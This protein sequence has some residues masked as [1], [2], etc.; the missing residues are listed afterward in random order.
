MSLRRCLVLMTFLVLSLWGAGTTKA[1]TWYVRADGG[2]RAQCDGKG[3]AAYPGHG[4]NRHCALNDMRALWDAHEY[5][6]LHWVIA[7]GDTVILDNTKQ[8]RIGWDTDGTHRDTEQWCWGWDQAP[9]GC[10]NPVIPAGTAQKHTRILGRNYEH[11]NVGNQPDKSKMTQVFGGHGVWTTMFLGSA[12]YVDVQCLEVTRHSQCVRHGEPRLPKN[13][14]SDYPLDDYDGDGMFTDASTHDLLLQD[15]WI[16][17]H[18]DRGINGAIGGVV[19]ANRVIISTNGMA[20]WD[21]DDGHQTQSVN[22]VWNFLNS[23]IE[24]SGCNQEYPAVHP[25][26]VVACY[27]QSNGGYGDS[28]GTPDTGFDVNI[29]H[30]VFRYNVQDGPDFLHI[31]KGTHKL[32]I[33]N[34]RSY[35]NNGDQF[36][37]GDGFHS[38]LFVNNLVVANCMRLSQTMPGTP[39]GFNAH[40][41]DFCRGNDA[42]T[43]GIGAGGH[44]VM[45]NNTIVTYEPV[46]VDVECSQDNCSNST[47]IFRNNILYGIDNKGT[48]SQ[49]GK[50]GGPAGFYYSKAGTN[51]IRNNNI[52]FGVRKISCERSE[53]CV[54]PKLTGLPRFTKE[55]DLDNLDFHLAAGSPARNAGVRLPDLK[56]DFDG[57]PRPATGNYSIGALE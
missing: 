9:W 27:G 43:I 52:I 28:I 1:D 11:C 54:D 19:T 30:S 31:D 21:F 29:D 32:T 38:V 40:L 50:E 13:C 22:G 10:F 17:G 24:W 8:W 3:D 39:D 34:S 45:D 18:T 20:G 14:S 33:T 55:S 16:H 2:T 4:S 48:Y 26:P 12:Q 42:I 5:G 41:G 44:V 25:V 15:M 56:T 7:G 35:G 47:L 36:K 49:G 53:L 51:T 23:T 46:S 6:K 37:W 57:K